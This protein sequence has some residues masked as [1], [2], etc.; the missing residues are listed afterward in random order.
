MKKII[1]ICFGL[2]CTLNSYSQSRK[3]NDNTSFKL[4]LIGNPPMPRE[5]ESYSIS[6]DLSNLRKS[7][8]EAFKKTDSLT[9]VIPYFERDR[10]QIFSFDKLRKGE[11]KV[12]PI[13]FNY[14]GF[15]F[16][17]DSL[18]YNVDDSLPDT[19]KG[20]WIRHSLNS[21]S[22]FRLSIQ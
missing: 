21:N 3:V 16:N 10:V 13:Y 2:C 1:W 18:I 14:G 7:L 11:H 15:N 4:T 12:G 17:T 5:N 19:N 8:F 9:S 20:L 22:L 6:L